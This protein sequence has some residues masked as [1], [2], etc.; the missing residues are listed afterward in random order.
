ME[1]SSP[2][3]IQI[4]WR[5][6]WRKRLFSYTI[7]HGAWSF[8]VAKLPPE[9]NLSGSSGSQKLVVY[10]LHLA[11]DLLVRWGLQILDRNP[12]PNVLR[13]EFRLEKG[14]QNLEFS[15]IYILLLIF[16]E[17]SYLSSNRILNELLYRKAPSFHSSFGRYFNSGK[18]RFFLV[19]CFKIF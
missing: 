5:G 6:W 13:R 12:K 7:S 15:G 11:L 2:E 8:Q 17:F 16:R 10:P 14:F 4:E 19:V 3:A 18:I 1:T 9:T